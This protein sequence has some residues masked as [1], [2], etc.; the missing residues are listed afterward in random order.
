MHLLDKV[1][2]IISEWIIKNQ[3]HVNYYRLVTTE[4]GM[5]GRPSNDHFIRLCVL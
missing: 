2:P 4:T 5:V 1:F 3:R